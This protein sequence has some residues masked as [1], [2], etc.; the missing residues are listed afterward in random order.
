MLVEERV[1]NLEEVLAK[2]MEQS[3]VFLAAI[4]EDIAEI[5]ASNARTDRQLL[6]MQQQAEHDRQQ[7]ERNREQAERDR[8][9]WEQRTAESDQRYEQDRKA[10][11]QRR[12][13][14]DRRYEQDR[15]D[16]N[17]RLAEISDSMGTLIEDF[18]APCGFQLA[19]AIFA[20]EEADTCAIRIKRRHPTSPG[21]MMEIDLLAVGPTKLL[22]IE[23][24]RRMD[25]AK[26]AEY[27]QKLARLP[28]FFPELSHKAVHPAEA[29]VYL[30]P[31]VI[32]FLNREK[33]YGIALGED[34][35]QVINLGQF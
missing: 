11:E 34:A 14:S 8:K 9:A 5:R 31:S 22:V 1:T 26:A 16:F 3:S 10:S 25:A 15:K 7:V 4:H 19:R 18:V 2:F 32:A 30:E 24:K 20:T 35:M 29:S 17:K 13:E 27:R 23:V 28:E 21:E 33:L 6:E 12:A